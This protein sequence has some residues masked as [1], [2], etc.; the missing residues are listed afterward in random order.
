MSLKVNLMQLDMEGRRF[1]GE[2]HEDVLELDLRDAMIH[3]SGALKYDLWVEK[4]D[5]SLLVRGELSQ[6]FSFNCVRCLKT[7]E[8]V[9]ELSEWSAY[10]ALEGEDSQPVAD[11]EVD[12][13]PVL[14]EDVALALPHH[15][16]CVGGCVETV[17]HAS[18]PIDQKV[19]EDTDV[20][21]PWD[22]LDHLKLE[23]DKN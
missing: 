8:K 13:I 4:H 9:L 3:A 16:V 20:V 11:D 7:F 6:A 17:S 10:V 15:P 12:M 5:Q 19:V 23:K 14:R 21:S 18:P 22:A 2:L 1:H